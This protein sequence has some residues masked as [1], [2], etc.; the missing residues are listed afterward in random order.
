MIKV[1][2]VDDENIVRYGIKSLLSEESGIKVIAEVSSG[3][4]AL[5]QARALKPDVVI[6]DV[7]MPGIGGLEATRRLTKVDPS[8][9]VI[10][11][12]V[13]GDEP[14]PSRVLQA[15]AM[16]YLTKGS[17]PAEMVDA[18]KMVFRGKRYI[19]PEVAQQLALK[20]VTDSDSS[21]LDLLSEREMQVMLMII[22]GE[23]VL[24]I[25]DKLCLS[26]KTINSYRY[27]IFEKLKINS[28]V[29]LTHIAL[30]YGLLDE[31]EIS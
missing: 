26:P 30:R 5:K 14:V 17:S 2:I 20:H 27:R 31:L 13:Y 6:M 1:I 29:E 3:E 23:K 24:A 16:G 9:R 19:C 4:D 18:I 7:K 8:I 12:T 15:G 21:P 22:N 11:L 10:A 25:S 28:D